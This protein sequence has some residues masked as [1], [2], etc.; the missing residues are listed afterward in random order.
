MPK[1]SQP[2]STYSQLR[3]FPNTNM[4]IQIQLLLNQ[5]NTCDFFHR[6]GGEA[7]TQSDKRRVF[8]LNYRKKRNK[9]RMCIFGIRCLVRDT[10][11]SQCYKQ[12]NDECDINLV[13]GVTCRLQPLE[14]ILQQFSL[15]SSIVVG[16]IFVLLFVFVFLILF[17]FNIV[18]TY[19]S[20]DLLVIL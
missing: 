18:Q 16:F 8:H 11:I 12:K 17:L 9:K 10:D 3:Q 14:G 5:I 2:Y 6:Y 4:K 7:R 20:R 1:T 13:V 19:F 15:F